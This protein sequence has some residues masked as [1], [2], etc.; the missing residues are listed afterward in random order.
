MLTGNSMKTN[1]DYWD[2]VLENLP[3]SYHEWFIEEKKYLKKVITP[4]AK[5][6]EVGCGDGRSIFDL[7]SL[8]KNI[9]GIDHDDK[10][11]H[12][13][14]NKFSNEPSIQILKADATHLPFQDGE[15][16]FVICMT[17]FANFADNKFAVL[18][19]M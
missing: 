3:K 12:D 1:M 18:E 16:D 10:A 9:V 11:V 15:F 8:T 17:T 4:D 5:V 7:L 6:L 19:E 14:K 13:A 2:S